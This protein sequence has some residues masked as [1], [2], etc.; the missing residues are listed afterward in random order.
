MGL[1]IHSMSRIAGKPRVRKRKSA[2]SPPVKNTI[3]ARSR[4]L[5]A[6]NR[7][8]RQRTRKFQTIARELTH[9]LSSTDIAMLFVD[10]E[11]RIRSF[12]PSMRDLLDI[13][14]EDVGLSIR[15][16]ERHFD[17]TVLLADMQVALRMHQTREAEVKSKSGR[18]YVRLALPYRTDND[19]V[20]GIVLTFVDITRRKLA[21]TALRTSE[22][23]HRMI[24]ESVSEYAILL[25]DTEGRFVNWTPSAMRIFGYK[26]SEAVGQH[27][28]MLHPTEE[29]NRQALEKEMQIAREQKS[30]T[31]ERW[32]V[33]KD[34]TRFWGTGVLSALYDESSRLYG[35][36]KVLRDN[37]ER[38]LA[39][40][41]LRQAKIDAEL[42]NSAKDFFL[43]NVSHELRTPLSVMLLWAKMLRRQRKIKPQQLREGL[44]AIVKS[45]EEQQ[46]LI[47]DLMDT[48]RIVV[49]KMRLEMEDLKLAPLVK[50][51]LDVVRPSALEKGLRLEHHIDPKAGTVHADALRLQQ[52]LTNLLNNAVKFT[53]EGGVISLDLKRLGDVVEIRVSDTGQGI[54]AEFI[55]RVFDRFAQADPASVRVNGGLGLGLSIAR[56]LVQLHG[57]TIDLHSEGLNKGTTFTVRLPL[58]VVA[59]RKTQMKKESAHLPTL[60]G[61]TILLVEDVQH[62]RR[63]LSAVLAN[64]KATVVAV[65]SAHE[66]LRRFTQSRPDLLL[67][68]IGL[69]KVSGY[70]L[71]AEIRKQ[72]EARRQKP[73]PAVALTA[74][75]DERSRQLAM[76]NGFQT[77]LKK[78]VTPAEL[79]TTLKQL[80]AAS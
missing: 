73:V 33:R 32:H 7:Y 10:K 8:L 47:E 2:T 24:L 78:P 13:S 77:V 23:R 42:A 65:D 12:T 70:E 11:F 30:V 51:A 49:G 35:Y 54:S 4:A 5:S 50:K 48:S 63:A 41:A 16:L 37:T 27:L 40:E 67:S 18:V 19:R 21:E 9:L 1:T 14:H 79:L 56:Q 3:M 46:A 25:L 29:R 68:D 31:V 72:E 61:L 76:Q 64:A 28:E 45:A 80:S 62:T 34:G 58:P 44:N 22:E 39:L 55:G 17:D 60:R 38:K 75:V 36:V 66:A 71:L 43:A 53:P 15:N 6:S 26:S 20:E 59:A 69:G 52:V 57:G 74:F